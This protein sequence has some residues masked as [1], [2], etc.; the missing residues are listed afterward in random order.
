MT[1]MKR[2]ITEKRLTQSMHPINSPNI[3]WK[4]SGE[5]HMKQ[6]V[7]IFSHTGKNQNWR[8]LN[9]CQMMIN[10]KKQ[11]KEKS[12]SKNNWK[13]DMLWVLGFNVTTDMLTP[14]WPGWNAKISEALQCTKDRVPASNKSVTCKSL[15]C[16]GNQAKIFRDCC[17]STEN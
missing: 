4:K 13:L 17:R 8:Q 3:L 2:N 14:L 16:S 5:E 9:C 11:Y 15:S 1:A 6:L 12:V 10:T 7:L